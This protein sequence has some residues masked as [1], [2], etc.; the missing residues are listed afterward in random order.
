MKI[1]NLSKKIGIT[2]I[3]SDL[4]TK[5]IWTVYEQKVLLLIIKK[6]NPY[7]K[8]IS[9]EDF[10]NI[11]FYNIDVDE[12]PTTFTF[13]RSDLI[14]VGFEPKH[15]S[16]KIDEVTD[17]LLDKKIK[18]SHP[19]VLD[20][21]ES[22]A[23]A[24]WF[25]NAYYNKKTQKID[26]IISP[27]A[28]KMLIYFSKYS[29][30]GIEH[31]ANINN[32][33]ALNVY[34]AIKMEI[35]SKYKR[36]IK[37]YCIYLDDFRN[38]FNIKNRY[39]STNMLKNRVLSPLVVKI[40]ENTDLNLS[41]K[42]IKEGRSFSKIMFYFDYKLEYKDKSV[43]KKLSNKP[44]VSYSHDIN[45]ESIKSPF[46]T[47]FKN[48]GINKNKILHIENTYSLN[49]ITKAIQITQ[50]AIEKGNIKTTPAAFFIGTLDNKQLQEQVEFKESQE[51]EIKRALAEE[52]DY[53]QK[54]INNN[55]D[56]IS[57]Y[58]SVKSAG[59]SFEL[60]PEISDE[61]ANLACI[62]IDKYKEFKPKFAVLEQ[63]FFDMKRKKEIRPNMYTFLHLIKQY[64]S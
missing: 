21:H 52:Y 58:L 3:L 44:L 42:L 43:S 24:N 33:Y 54:F 53:I 25:S 31:I 36:N 29:Y 19:E 8:M 34:M 39:K 6:L 51:K 26:L 48:W 38:A 61:M 47:I 57:N 13:N 28:L 10:E 35:D 11:N 37:E 22:F 55:S 64:P 14:K 9:R 23:K 5:K 41:Y 59:G 40:S 46:E 2:N 27:L 12:I 16:R 50:E 18:T 15:F 17:L 20:C 30:I 62:N 1:L 60:L 7:M 56:K 63:G 45:M 32:V 49:S 4:K